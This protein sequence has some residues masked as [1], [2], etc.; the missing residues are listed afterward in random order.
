MSE[1]TPLKIG[2]TGKLFGI[3]LQILGSIKYSQRQ[4]GKTYRWENLYCKGADGN[5]YWID[6]D[7]YSDQYRLYKEV[8]F[9]LQKFRESK[10][11]LIRPE[12]RDVLTVVEMGLGSVDNIQGQIPYDIQQKN[13]VRFIDAIGG[14]GTYSLEFS[15]TFA[16][17][18]A[19]QN[20]SKVVLF[21]AF[22]LRDLAKKTQQK[23]NS[24]I[25]WKLVN[26]VMI[27]PIVVGILGLMVSFVANTT[28]YEGEITVCD[29]T[30]T[31][32]TEDAE[33]IGPF[34]FSFWPV[35]YRFT[36]Q[37]DLKAVS[38]SVANETW[39]SVTTEILNESREPING[40][41]Y[42][43]YNEYWIEGGERGYERV[44]S[45]SHDLRVT[46]PGEHYIVMYAE[47]SA[48]NFDSDHTIN[49]RVEQ[50]LVHETPF[51]FML[52]GTAIYYFLR[53]YAKNK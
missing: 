43:M 29:E 25:K 47:S 1:L 51:L 30:N 7:M 45:V 11:T 13:K 40:I 27:I 37:T 5:E 32:C 36:V 35:I 42:D 26:K 48:D 52:I 10:G 16:H 12:N 53:F 50:R 38:S 9:D 44:D 3:Q 15:E 28:I 18:Y 8:A 31:T 4:E 41:Y 22:G 49:L 24:R 33:L 6:Y 46:E 2:N 34:E 20:V 19:G 14:K 23:I 39:I 17:L 21:N